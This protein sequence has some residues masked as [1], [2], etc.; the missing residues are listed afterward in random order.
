MIAYRCYFLSGDDKIKGVEVIE[1]PTDTAA[2]QQA[3]QTLATCGHPAIEVWHKARRVGTV[4][5]KS[6]NEHDRAM[7]GPRLTRDRAWHR[8]YHEIWLHHFN[9]GPG[10]FSQVTPGPKNRGSHASGERR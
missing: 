5:T 8:H 6:N 7:S 1:C 3:E 4:G 9:D 10:P 2:L